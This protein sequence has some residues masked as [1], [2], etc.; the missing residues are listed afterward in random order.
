MQVRVSSSWHTYQWPAPQELRGAS[1]KGLP[2]A[3]GMIEHP[4]QAFR[5]VR[6]QSRRSFSAQTQVTPQGA[7]AVPGLSFK[8]VVPS[9]AF[10]GSDGSGGGTG[11]TGGPSSAGPGSWYQIA[12]ASP[13]AQ[14]RPSRVP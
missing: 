5:R 14:T 10:L 12:P 3:L 2:I 1:G 9:Q 4:P 6:L 8:G 11:F 13:T 7:Q